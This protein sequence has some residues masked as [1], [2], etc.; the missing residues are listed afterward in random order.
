[1]IVRDLLSWV[2][3]SLVIAFQALVKVREPLLPAERINTFI[4]GLQ[5][6]NSH[7]FTC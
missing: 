5:F 3:V 2:T 7:I 4:T 1:M 6:K